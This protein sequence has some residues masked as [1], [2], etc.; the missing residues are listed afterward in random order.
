[1][2]IVFGDKYFSLLKI[3]SSTPKV[4][5]STQQP[6]SHSSTSHGNALQLLPQD[7]IRSMKSDEQ[8]EYYTKVIQK[9][10]V[11]R[12]Q[13]NSGDAMDSSEVNQCIGSAAE[14]DSRLH[15][16]PTN[17]TKAHFAVDLHLADV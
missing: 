13:L 4:L 9:Y 3:T 15:P 5:D 6:S 7:M 12:L 2:G 10:T 8:F 11:L 16:L 1:M 14:G 17:V